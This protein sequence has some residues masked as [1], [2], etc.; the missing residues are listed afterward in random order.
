MD[1][2]SVSA[3]TMAASDEVEA[4]QGAKYSDVHGRPR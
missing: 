3:N 1:M 4:A 2:L